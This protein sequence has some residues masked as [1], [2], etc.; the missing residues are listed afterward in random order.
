MMVTAECG[1]QK[2]GVG[3]GKKLGLMSRMP[4][5]QTTASHF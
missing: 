4:Q 3:K 5:N 1:T 2:H